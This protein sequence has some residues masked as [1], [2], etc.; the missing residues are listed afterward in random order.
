MPARATLHPSLSLSPEQQYLR[1]RERV[2][3]LARNAAVAAAGELRALARPPALRAP[4]AVAGAEIVPG[5]LDRP[6]GARPS[7]GRL[8][9]LHVTL[10]LARSVAGRFA[11]LDLGCGRG[12]HAVWLEQRLSRLDAYTGVD[13]EANA[14]WPRRSSARVRFVEAPAEA[15]AAALGPVDDFT[16]VHSFCALEHMAGDAAVLDG[17]S[18]WARSVGHPV[19]QVHHLPATAALPIYRCHGY[20]VY[21]R[22]DV[23]RL[24]DLMP[25]GSFAIPIGG[26]RTWWLQ[27]ALRRRGP[28]LYTRRLVGECERTLGRISRAPLFWSLVSLPL[29][30]R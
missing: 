20:R 14:E 23:R 30:P 7:P 15:Y 29:T 21:S 17:V 11:M 12:D 19:T 25:P 16:F 4:A 5:E 9:A 26:P 24:L 22:G 18:R 3:W 28:G 10:A 2:E 27:A 13:V 6:V 1:V 8:I